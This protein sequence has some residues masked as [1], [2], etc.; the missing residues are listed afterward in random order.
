MLDAKE[1]I[2][3]SNIV[4]KLGLCCVAGCGGLTIPIHKEKFLI[5]SFKNEVNK[6]EKGLIHKFF[7]ANKLHL[8]IKGSFD[9]SITKGV[10]LSRGL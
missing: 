3:S 9:N 7:F 4:I 8:K 10:C 2:S 5:F 6:V 1:S